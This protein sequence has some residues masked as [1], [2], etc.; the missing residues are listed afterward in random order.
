MN[1]CLIIDDDPVFV[2]ILS[3]IVKPYDLD[4]DH[5]GDAPS[6]I[7]AILAH[8]YDLIFLDLH[9][10]GSPGSAVVD[11][12]RRVKPHSIARMIAVTGS[13]GAQRFGDI[14]VVDKGNV[15]TLAARVRELLA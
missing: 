8:E 14:P 13:P 15:A 6:A 7:Q 1:R 12:I 5:A 4:V 10:A 2:E 9:L 11:H 3:R